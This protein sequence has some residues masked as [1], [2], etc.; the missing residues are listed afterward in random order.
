L[1][2][3]IAGGLSTGDAARA[4]AGDLDPSFGNAGIVELNLAAGSTTGEAAYDVR[5]QSDGTIV[6]MGRGTNS[7]RLSRFLANG[8]FDGTFG[9]GGTI[10]HTFSGLVAGGSL[11]IDGSGRLLVAGALVVDDDRDVFV[12]RFTPAG[13]IDSSFGGGDGWTS[14]DYTPGTVDAGLE[15]G[16][17]V[18]VGAGDQ[19]IIG[20]WAD[21][22]GNIFHPSDRQMAVARLELDGDLDPTFGSGGIALAAV[23]NALDDDVRGMEIDGA[24]RIVAIGTSS[25]PSGPANTVLARWLPTG[26]PDTS[27]DADGVRFLDLAEGGGHDGGF[28]LTFDGAGRILALGISGGDDPTV[29]RLLDDGGLDDGWGGD[30]IVRQSFFGGQDVTERVLVQAD[31]KVLVTGWPVVPVGSGWFHMAVQRFTADGVRDDTFG[32]GGVV[33]TSPAVNERIYGAVLLPDQR[34]LVAGGYDN[35]VGLVMARFLPDSCVE[36]STTT[37]TGDGPEPSDPGQAVSVAYSVAA[38]AGT[39]TGD[40]V[41]SDGVDSCTG[42]VAAGG[43]A[44]TVSSGGARTLTASY[45]GDALFCA[46]SDSEAHQVRAPTMTAV[47]GDTP[48]P[49]QPGQTV[50][51]SV[52]VS[53][54]L[55][56]GGSPAGTVDV[57]DGLGAGCSIT[58][59]DGAGSCGLVFAALGDRTITATYAGSTDH[60]GSVGTAEHQVLDL[61]GP[62]VATVRDGGDLPLDA[63]ATVR[64]GVSTLR[65]TFDEGV[66]G[67]AVTASY[68]L[69]AAGADGDLGPLACTDPLGLDDVELTIADAV[70]DGAPGGATVALGLA[71]PLP[72]GLVRLLVC[73]TI[74]DTAGNAL[75]GDGDGTGGDAFARTFR[76]DRDN[77]FA[78][79]HFDRCPVSLAAW[80]TEATPPNAV[81]PSDEDADDSPLS[82]SVE[83]FSATA[84]PSGL[85][86]CVPIARSGDHRLT[87]RARLDGVSGATGIATGSCHFFTGAG[88]TGTSLG[89]VSDSAAVPDL[90][91]GWSDLRFS[92]AAPPSGA[93]AACAVSLAAADAGEPLFTGYLDDLALVGPLFA[94][95]F[96]GGSL[97]AWSAAEGVAGGEP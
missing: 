89:I 5:L 33:T 19:P 14:F 49:S 43:C 45:Q 65:V 16:S 93:S 84:D 63:C 75:D 69:V 35:D 23:G 60:V 3:A 10:V 72:D 29:A 79:G 95:G 82:G 51:V 96:E 61:T 86:Q 66:V 24:G 46:S 62:Q 28:D 74:E 56:G 31:G 77:L 52:A 11:A 81:E 27:F 92:V 58:L 41:V 15:L 4:A 1:L 76:V 7:V 78:E 39:P 38:G 54:L 70:S 55:A 85:G 90:A 48:D 34:L 64:R 40:V 57:A 30:G 26:A 87:V 8:S 67:E 80:T 83:V 20:G 68:R 18:R 6:T 12:A 88:C 97:A 94:D 17:V 47:V 53:S 50:T 44:L 71:A 73:P 59:A 9:S 32:D 25:P 21:A 37:I 36:P 91:G 2:I 22:N 13:A 42:T